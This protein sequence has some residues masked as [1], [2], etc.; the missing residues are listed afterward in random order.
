MVP[1]VLGGQALDIEDNIPPSNIQPVNPSTVSSRQSAAESDAVDEQAKPS[2]FH[3]DET[4]KG[5]SFLPLH[6]ELRP[7]YD[8]IAIGDSAC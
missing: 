2:P 1:N 8:L 3:F 7:E 4:T 6:H 5:R